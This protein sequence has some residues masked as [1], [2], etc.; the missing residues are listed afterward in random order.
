MVSFVSQYLYR[1]ILVSLFVLASG[2]I[3]G[4]MQPV[5]VMSKPEVVAA[6]GRGDTKVT[7]NHTKEPIDSYSQDT[8][9]LIDTHIQE[10]LS[11]EEI[12]QLKILII[13]FFAV[14]AFDSSKLGTTDHVTHIIDTGDSSP[15]CVVS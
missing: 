7:S 3:L 5:T 4:Q 14:F 10:S 6:I 13:K 2:D 12:Q 9:Q 15:V 11:V 1:T 8:C